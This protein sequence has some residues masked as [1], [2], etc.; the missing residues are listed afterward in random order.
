MRPWL[1]LHSEHRRARFA[2]PLASGQWVEKVQS[3]LF[4]FV[5]YISQGCQPPATSR[6]NSRARAS[7]CFASE[8]LHTLLGAWR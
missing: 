3:T 5:H 2:R 8:Q 6:I 4:N 7:I 1:A